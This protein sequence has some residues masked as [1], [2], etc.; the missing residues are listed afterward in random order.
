MDTQEVFNRNMERCLESD[1]RIILRSTIPDLHYT[2]K[3]LPMHR[4]RRLLRY[5]LAKQPLI[6]SSCQD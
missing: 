2:M 4:P 5:P 3:Q 6:S 1:T